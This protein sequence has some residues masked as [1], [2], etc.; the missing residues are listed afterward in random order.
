MTKAARGPFVG[1]M[2]PVKRKGHNALDL[3][4]LSCQFPG[5]IIKN[6]K[7]ESSPEKENYLPGCPN[8]VGVNKFLFNVH[9]QQRKKWEKIGKK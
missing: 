8:I 2:E 5:E 3:A 4:W 7:E 1:H 9:F 6:S